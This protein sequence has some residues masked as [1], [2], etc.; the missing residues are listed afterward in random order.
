M[1]VKMVWSLSPLGE[2]SWRG[3]LPSD[4]RSQTCRGEH[5]KPD[6][7]HSPEGF[8]KRYCLDPRLTTRLRYVHEHNEALDLEPAPCPFITTPPIHHTL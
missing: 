2:R 5:P 3:G 8:D 1:I 4:A 6:T 7:Q